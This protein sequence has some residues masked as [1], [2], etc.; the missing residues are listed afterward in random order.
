MWWG[1]PT[2]STL[3][4]SHFHVVKLYTLMLINFHVAPQNNKNHVK[5]RYCVI[6][7]SCFKARISFDKTFMLH[8][9]MDCAKIACCQTWKYNGRWLY[10]FMCVT[11]SNLKK[12][13]KT[14]KKSKILEKYTSVPFVNILQLTN[15][16]IYD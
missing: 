10:F 1:F 12:I 2:K 6:E 14:Y 5:P 15:E 11:V 16:D 4:W 8:H 7:L 3:S 9:K 13:S